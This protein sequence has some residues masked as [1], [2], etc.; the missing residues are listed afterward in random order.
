M[1]GWVRRRW[2]TRPGSGQRAV[3]WLVVGEH[4]HHRRGS[5]PAEPAWWSPWVQSAVVHWCGIW[6][7]LTVTP[8]RPVTPWLS[9][10]LLVTRPLLWPSQTKSRWYLTSVCDSHLHV[11]V[12][13]LRRCPSILPNPISPNPI[14]PNPISPNP[15]SPNPISPN[16]IS[17][18]PISPNRVLPN[19]V[20]PNRVIAESRFAESRFAS[21]SY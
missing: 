6:D 5:S 14:S 15:I 1:F 21:E 11:T 2:A 7:H 17:P 4:I 3:G 13:Y 16:P 9:L 19:R 12:A 18:N 20:L 10:S 8:C